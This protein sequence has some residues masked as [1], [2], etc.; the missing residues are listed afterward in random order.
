M[1]EIGSSSGSMGGAA[2]ASSSA[3]ETQDSQGFSSRSLGDF[4]SQ[5]AENKSMVSLDHGMGKSS[6]FARSESLSK[7][8]KDGNSMFNLDNPVRDD[9]SEHFETPHEQS[10]EE[11]LT[12]LFGEKMVH[13]SAHEEIKE[14]RKSSFNDL[15]RN[16]TPLWE[17]PKDN[18]EQNSI[19]SHSE[20]L[21]ELSVGEP[22]TVGSEKHD[23]Q[24]A[25]ESEPSIKIN[26]METQE[27]NDAQSHQEIG[28]ITFDT[29]QHEDIE[30][31]SV[32][33]G[34]T[35]ENTSQSEFVSETRTEGT[36]QEEP[37]ETTTKAYDNDVNENDNAVQKTEPSQI[38]VPDSYQEEAPQAVIALQKPESQ[39]RQ[40]IIQQKAAK[41]SATQSK[42]EQAVE[43]IQTQVRLMTNTEEVSI[44][45]PKGIVIPE[46][47][48]ATTATVMDTA[49]LT[50]MIRTA[51]AP[52]VKTET[53]IV[54]KANAQTQPEVQTRVKEAVKPK[55]QT[56]T[57]TRTKA[58]LRTETE[59]QREFDKQHKQI[60]EI[61]DLKKTEIDTHRKEIEEQEE[62]EAKETQNNENI[63]QIEKDESDRDTKEPE[64][65]V[66]LT[67]KKAWFEK[68]VV[69]NDH[70]KRKIIE[71]YALVHYAW[72]RQMITKMNGSDVARAI[73]NNRDREKMK[74][75]SILRI[76]QDGSIDPFADTLEEAEALTS[77]EDLNELIKEA[78]E[79][80]TATNFTA[81]P[82]EE[83]VDG[84]QIANV[85][86]WEKK[87]LAN[88][89]D[90]EVMVHMENP[91]VKKPEFV[92][93]EVGE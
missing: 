44:H 69:A 72:L 11:R 4:K 53:Q 32:K 82:T 67:I 89:G 25:P 71:A 84:E 87:F 10:H 59:T 24:E 51:N 54:Q 65:E 73:K 19:H 8:A 20:S 14:N 21:R 7:Q 17:R 9:P 40:E 64:K 46:L 42:I 85:H 60:T 27:K 43:N 90:E 26:E 88:L 57:E 36:Y 18:P 22:Q 75:Q 91:Y 79:K 5:G 50:E 3:V 86:N 45:I 92:S 1:S 38:D 28:H 70:R 62:A 81:N 35:T 30:M 41:P 52:A 83:I 48:T 34:K 16:S 12:E 63:K 2:I 55:T 47:S 56:E 80:N 76:D 66:I 61:K 77:F 37:Q 49:T 39:S 58:D 74:S 31:D 23:D 78:E 33:D 29:D 93:V 6:S 68:D 15:M 13:P